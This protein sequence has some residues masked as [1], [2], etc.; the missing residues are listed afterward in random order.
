M[1]VSRV[2][3]L[4]VVAMLAPALAVMP[5]CS[6]FQSAN[7]D[8]TV[9]PSED[10]AEIFINGK[11]VGTGTTTVKL[12]R[13]A[14]YS[15][16][17]KSGERAATAKV[18]RKIS[19]TGVADIVGGILFLFPFIGVFSPGF[20]DLNPQQLS[21]A[22]PQPPPGYAPAPRPYSSVAPA[23]APAPA[24]QGRGTPAVNT[25]APGGPESGSRLPQRRPAGQ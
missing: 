21:I 15:V 1:S 17:A 3:R 4:I 2:C 20:W 23:P 5:G 25:R 8:L 10:N 19:G 24:P 9:V 7:Q 18:G 13:G 11:P 6:I 14:D 12:K 22:L 16:M